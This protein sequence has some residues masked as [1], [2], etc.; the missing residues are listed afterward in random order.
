MRIEIWSDVI[1]PWCYIGKRRL[2]TALSGVPAGTDVELVW[3]SFELDPDAP[4]QQSGTLEEMLAAKYGLSSAEA[5]AANARIS[6][7]AAAEGLEYRLEQAR[8]GNTFAAHRLLHLAAERGRQAVLEERLFRAYFT[9]GLPIGDPETLLR[10]AREAG[11]ESAE[12]AEV[13]AGDAYAAAVRADE[14]EA[15]ALGAQGVPFFVFERKVGVSGA[16]PADVLLRALRQ[17]QNQ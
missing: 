3:R 14:A 9:D 13:L 4:A 6:A 7:V 17:A 11:L 2:E 15:A 1:C 10:L 12:A 5:R 8:P 16:Q